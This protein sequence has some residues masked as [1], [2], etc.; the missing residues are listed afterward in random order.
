MSA[1][2]VCE[3]QLDSEEMAKADVM[4]EVMLPA[5]RKPPRPSG[6][7]RFVQREVARAL[8]S[9]CVMLLTRTMEGDLSALKVLLQMAQMALETETA[10]RSG[11]KKQTGF[12]QK[13]LAGFRE[14]EARENSAKQDG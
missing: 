12:A 5:M 7:R 2:T 14:W 8:P 11:T 9:I 4:T 13:I 3:G 6:C 10:E 1:R